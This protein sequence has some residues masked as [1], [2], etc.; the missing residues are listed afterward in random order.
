M[1][2]HKKDKYGGLRV[3][4]EEMTDFNQKDKNTQIVLFVW[5]KKQKRIPMRN[6]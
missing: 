2:N 1:G 3:L 4:F 5:I 6:L